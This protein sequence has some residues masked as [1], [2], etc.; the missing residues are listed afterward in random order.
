MQIELRKYWHGDPKDLVKP[1]EDLVKDHRRHEL[2]QV[3]TAPLYVQR[4][5]PMPLN[6]H[7]WHVQFDYE[8]TQHG[9]SEL[10]YEITILTAC[11]LSRGKEID[12]PLSFFTADD[13]SEYRACIESELES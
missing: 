9:T 7:G 13:L 5:K 4:T 1:L 6:D 2:H 11:L 12:L 10:P 3:R 8:I